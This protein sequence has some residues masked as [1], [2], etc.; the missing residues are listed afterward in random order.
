MKFKLPRLL[1][2]WFTSEEAKRRTLV[3]LLSDFP[4]QT[5]NELILRADGKLSAYDA[6]KL[7]V[8]LEDEELVQVRLLPDANN[9][10]RVYHHLTDAGNLLALRYLNGDQP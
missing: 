10:V 5:G 9:V 3:L 6:Y 1:R 4:D 8:D 7:L 2:S